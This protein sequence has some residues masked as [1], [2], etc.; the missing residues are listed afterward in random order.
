[1]RSRGNDIGILE[2]SG[3]DLG[4]DKTGDM[5]HIDNK[6]STDRVS[7]LPHALIVNQTTISR[8]PGDEDLGA[9]EDS[10]LG[11]LV[12]I[13]DASLKVNSVGHGLKVG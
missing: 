11:E 1:M 3:D 12:I 6:V 9:V 8:G 10:V 13:D 2:R 4:G 7:N 5:G